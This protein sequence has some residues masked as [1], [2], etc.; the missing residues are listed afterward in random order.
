MATQRYEPYNRNRE[1]MSFAAERREPA[2]RQ[3]STDRECVCLEKLSARL[4]A[5]TNLAG[6]EPISPLRVERVCCAVLAGSREGFRMER[7]A[8][9]VAEDY[10]GDFGRFARELLDDEAGTIK[11]LCDFEQ[12]SQ[13]RP[14]A[15]GYRGRRTHS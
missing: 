12:A 11:R 1:T 7:V 2:W 8:E 6:S 15:I 14:W 10:L 9:M 5:V 3:G 4:R 13:P